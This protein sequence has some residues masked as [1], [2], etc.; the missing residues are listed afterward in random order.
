MKKSKKK[1]G[2]GADALD[3]ET[4]TVIENAVRVRTRM[5]VR[6]YAGNI[7]LFRST[8]AETEERAED[9]ETEDEIG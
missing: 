4:K 7:R 9:E 8:V 2:G 5:R 3:E 1:R 6:D